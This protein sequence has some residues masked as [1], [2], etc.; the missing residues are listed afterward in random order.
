MTELKDKHII[1]GICGGIAA[2]KSAELARKLHKEGAE[3]QVVMTASAKE[4]I[5]PLTFAALTH[6][7]VRDQLWDTSAETG[8]NHIALAKWADAIVIAPATANFIAKLANGFADNLLLTLCLATESPIAVMPAMN[9][10]MW[11]AYPTQKNIQTLKD[12][13]IGVWGPEEGQQAC[14]DLGPG[15][16]LEPEQALGMLRKLFSPELFQ[17]A[18]VVISAGP[19]REAIDPVRYL[20]NHSSGKMGFALASA[21]FLL[22]A[23]VHLIAGPVSLP[24]PMGVERTDVTTAAEMFAAVQS[25]ISKTDIFMSAAAVSDYRPKTIEAHKIKKNRDDRTLFLQPTEDILT[26]V[27]AA[28]PKPFTVGFAAETQQVKAA[29]KEKLIHKS[30]DMIVANEVG[31]TKGFNSDYNAATVLWPDGELEIPY[32]LKKDVAMEIMVV[33]AQRYREAHGNHRTSL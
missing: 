16:M 31:S 6:R 26:W 5:S 15:R 1:L 19:T 24:T 23:R 22:G 27:T 28:T 30:L 4:F 29:A 25:L 32:G 8:M 17:G 11:H 21:A 9:Q 2:Y 13:G 20:S 10:R 33:V 7:P 18:R 3:V 14:G 12:M